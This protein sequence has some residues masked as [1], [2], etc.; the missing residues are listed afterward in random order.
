MSYV[1]SSVIEKPL[2]FLYIYIY[3]KKLQ[4]IYY[5]LETL[6]ILTSG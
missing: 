3:D 6:M 5:Q 2:F 1:D 4:K